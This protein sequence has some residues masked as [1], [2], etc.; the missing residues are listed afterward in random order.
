LGGATE[1]RASTHTGAE[2]APARV[3]RVALPRWV[4]GLA[5]AAG[6]MTERT[7]R[8]MLGVPVLVLTR[9]TRRRRH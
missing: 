2:A 6:Q 7:V 9:A 3:E 4:D 8:V 1:T 5:R